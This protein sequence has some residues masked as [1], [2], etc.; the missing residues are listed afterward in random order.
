MKTA[1]GTRLRPQRERL[2]SSAGHPRGR[3][4]RLTLPCRTHV[5]RPSLLSRTVLVRREHRYPSMA[6][7]P[8]QFT[9]LGACAHTGHLLAGSG[10]LHAL[11]YNG[12]LGGMRVPATTLSS[13]GGPDA[14]ASRTLL[15][16]G[17]LEARGQ[18]SLR[19]GSLRGSGRGIPTLN[20]TPTNLCPR[21]SCRPHLLSFG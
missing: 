21:R 12:T 17:C 5:H 2:A 4:K 7:Y 11:G 14:E 16:V 15:L 3:A 10:C 13:R 19:Q 18:L 9:F 20:G 8:V 6:G 1:A